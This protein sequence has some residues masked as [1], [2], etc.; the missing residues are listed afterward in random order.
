MKCIKKNMKA[1][2]KSI[3][4]YATCVCLYSPCA[5]RCYITSGCSSTGVAVS[6]NEN[7][8]SVSQSN[9]DSTY[10]TKVSFQSNTT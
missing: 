1:A 10:D 2:T 9:Y 6:G 4:T 7:Q 3:E 5:C 8:A